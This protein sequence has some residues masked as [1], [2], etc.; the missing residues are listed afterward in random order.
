LSVALEEFERIET[1]DLVL[2]PRIP[3]APVMRRTEHSGTTGGK[4]RAIVVR[5]AWVLAASGAFEIRDERLIFWR[6]VEARIDTR[7]V[8]AIDEARLCYPLAFGV[9]RAGK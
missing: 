2:A 3:N 7:H 8:E 6:Q 4:L 9:L 5:C 1:P